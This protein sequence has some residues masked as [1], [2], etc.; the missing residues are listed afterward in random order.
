M[1]FTAYTLNL[2][3]FGLFIVVRVAEVLLGGP[4]S[5]L[6]SIFVVA[7][8]FWPVLVM[9]KK[10]TKRPLQAFVLLTN[11]GLIS[12]LFSIAPFMYYTAN[13]IEMGIFLS[14][15]IGVFYILLFPPFFL[16]AYI[17]FNMLIGKYSDYFSK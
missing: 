15:F 4:L 1:I 3:F 14:V 7:I 2:I 11:L 10:R 9:L 12:F 6:F 13:E 16:N 5:N 8:V 17:S